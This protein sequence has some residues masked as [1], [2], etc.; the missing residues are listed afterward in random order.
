[1]R[2]SR[3]SMMSHVAPLRFHWVARASC[4]A[5]RLRIVSSHTVQS[6]VAPTRRGTVSIPGKLRRRSAMNVS[7]AAR[8]L[9]VRSSTQT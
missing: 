4:A 6:S 1:M 3:T 5:A 7:A 9:S 2:P 8:P